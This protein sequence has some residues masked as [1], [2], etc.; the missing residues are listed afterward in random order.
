MEAQQRYYQNDE[1]V[2]I[3]ITCFESMKLKLKP[4]PSVKKI[5]DAVIEKII[6]Q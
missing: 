2:C 3:Y 6:S 5:V 4:R 1:S